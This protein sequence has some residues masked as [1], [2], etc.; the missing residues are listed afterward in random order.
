MRATFRVVSRW[1]NGFQGEIALV[2]RGRDALE[3]WSLAFRP[4]WQ[5]VEMWNGRCHAETDGTLTVEAG[6]VAQVLP[7]GTGTS[8]GFIASGLPDDP[9]ALHC[10]ARRSPA[11]LSR[12]FRPVRHRARQEEGSAQS[13]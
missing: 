7:P 5:L 11:A 10:E 6:D 1:D 12:S 9:P 3:G 8:I 2:N 4:G 13:A